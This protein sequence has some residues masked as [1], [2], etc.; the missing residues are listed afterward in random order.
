MERKPIYL[1]MVGES[2]VD[3]SSNHNKYYRFI[4]LDDNTF[5]AEY[6]RVGAG[7]QTKV[8]P[9][10]R[11]DSIYNSKIKK[12][13][14]DQSDL[15]QEVIEDSKEDNDSDE[16]KKFSLISNI[17][18]REIIKRLYEY[19]NKTIQSS[20]KVEADVV[21]QAMVDK[22]QEIIDYL[23]GHYNNMT[24]EQFNNRLVK[25]FVTIPRKMK[26]VNDHLASNKQDFAKII[27]NEQ[28]I[29]DTMAGQVYK[30][31]LKVV[32]FDMNNN[33]ALET[34]I[35]DD[36]GIKMEEASNKDVEIIKKAMGDQASKFYKAWKVTNYETQDNFETYCDTHD[37]SNVKLLSHGSRNQ[38]WF[39]ILKMGLLMRPAGVI[40]QGSMF[41]SRA[42]YFGNP[43]KFHGGVAKS[44]GYTSNGGYWT[45]EYGSSG[46][47]GFY[48]VNLGKPYDIYDYDWKYQQ[49]DYDMLQKLQ[50]GAGHTFAHGG[51]GML[52]NDEIIIYKTEQC[53]IKYLVEIRQ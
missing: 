37:S 33:L 13:Y 2:N 11:W 15:M 28:S 38:N 29:L 34:S 14:V 39:N 41:G 49:L 5:R 12:G 46:F 6:G 27:E 22:A 24:V 30:P 40:V 10:S 44:I 1:I 25:L 45:R 17:S 36:M 4:P 47:I 42:L 26:V 52:K 19:A 9:M 3:N 16:D 7:M 23:S 53:T 50:P 20:Y 43:D 35:L 18:V 31:K 32:S 48:E 8:Y 21:T 51:T